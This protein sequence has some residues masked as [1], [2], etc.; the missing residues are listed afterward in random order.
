MK[1]ILRSIFIPLF[2]TTMLLLASC[3]KD[4]VSPPPQTYGQ[5]YFHLHTNIDTAEVDT[6]NVCTDATGRRIRLRIAQFYGSGFQLQKPDGSWLPV[7]GAYILK[8]IANEAYFIG[9]VPTGNYTNV[10][11]NVGLDPSRNASNPFGYSNGSIFALQTPSMWFGSTTQGY[12]FLNV[13]ALVDTTASHTGPVNIP[14]SYQ[15]GT[16]AMLKSVTF[17]AQSFSVVTNTITFV[18]IICDYGKLLQGINFK[19]QPNGTP[20]SNPAIATQVANNIPGM[21]HYEL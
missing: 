12:M 20:F 14:V 8:T 6:A 5:V 1:P 7:L 16:S 15:T 19:T 3:H 2:F 9:T 13:Q 17:P 11:F 21:F 18:H 4:S 10:T